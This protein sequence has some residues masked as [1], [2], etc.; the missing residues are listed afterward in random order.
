MAI[1]SLL[2]VDITVQ[3][4]VIDVEA[5][6]WKACRDVFPVVRKKGFAFNWGHAVFRHVQLLSLPLLPSEHI[7]PT[8]EM[9][10]GLNTAPHIT[11]LME[12]MYQ[13]WIN[14]T[15]WPVETI[16]EEAIEVDNTIALVN[17][18]QIQ[19]IPLRAIR[20]VQ[21]KL[22]ASWGEYRAVTLSTSGLF[23]RCS[24]LYKTVVA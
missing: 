13:T 4:I 11:P 2:E 8:F 1:W 10:S 16:H 23:K 6:L 9:I 15:V 14:S 24:K 7:R 18:Q 3:Q 22:F 12:Y 5:A 17:E 19:R 21:A 20:S